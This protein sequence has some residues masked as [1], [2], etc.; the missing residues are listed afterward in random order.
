MKRV[1]VAVIDTA[2]TSTF[3]ARMLS[4]LQFEPPSLNSSESTMSGYCPLPQVQEALE[5]YIH[6]RQETLKIRQ[7]LTKHLKRQFN[8]GDSLAHLSVAVPTSSLEVN[9]STDLPEG[10]YT[11][12]LE[13]LNAH[14]KAK[15]QYD[16]VKAEIEELQQSSRD[17][18]KGVD[19]GG[20][21]IADHITL[22]KQRQ[23]HR[24]LEIIQD[25]LMQLEESEPNPSKVDLAEHLKE[26]LG[27]PPQ[28]P[29]EVTGHVNS[30]GKVDD[31]VFRLK[32]EL[33]AA[34]SQL[35]RANAE[36]AAAEDR[37]K[38]LPDP[39]TASHVA[40]L[41]AAR[42]ELI[43]WIEGEL[44]KISE[45]ESEDASGLDVSEDH[46]A[47]NTEP[48]SNDAVAA[49]VDDHYERYVEARKALIDQIE[50]AARQSRTTLPALQPQTTQSTGMKTAVEAKD[51]KV[52]EVLQYLPSLIAASREE[53]AL[54]Q[55]SSHLRRQLAIAS[56]ETSRMIQR[57]AG[58]S[59]LVTP[60]ATGME[61]WAKAAD[62]ASAKTTTFVQDQV[63]IGEENV[64]NSRKV[65][66]KM[67]KRRE[68]A[69][70]LKGDL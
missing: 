35:D 54:L 18:Q 22:V 67:H 50:A 43:A 39:S 14:R 28:P 63:R 12:Y 10:L 70:K 16:S 61:A 56:E 1:D 34:K 2:W 3:R 41:R 5:P 15:E 42:D 65:L 31:V 36:K 9:D 66:D 6:S 44:A 49:A 29:I 32:K 52:S 60:N 64:A 55:Q 24:K 23:Q 26:T 46:E 30:D 33:L 40:A 19:L 59:L 58:E 69:E 13:A 21:G 37:T 8:N 11:Q 27:E 48:L 17:R 47:A 45:N 4:D 62:D 68:A 51:V 20:S 7:A 38:N 53:A 25:A 57:L